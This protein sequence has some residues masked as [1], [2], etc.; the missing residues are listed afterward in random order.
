VVGAGFDGDN[1]YFSG[2]AYVF[3]RPGGGWSETL[4]ED[5][6]LLASDGAHGEHFG[7]SVSISG[8]TVVIGA[9]GDRDNGHSSG[10][11]YV[12]ARS[13]L[14]DLNCDGVVDF[15]DIDAFV[16][17]LTSAG[18]PDPFDGYY[19][20]WPDCNPMLA[21]INADRAVNL[22]DIDPFAELLT[23]K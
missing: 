3:E 6:K 4:N 16:L 2:S 19:A 1:G 23:D 17:A 18:N 13:P 5:A 10:S 22:F 9:Q 21:D 8:D 15:L 14:G 7:H 11:A 12:F 20:G